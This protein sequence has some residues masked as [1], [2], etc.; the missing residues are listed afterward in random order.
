MAINPIGVTRLTGLS[1]G[2]DSDTII[3]NMMKIE[4]LKLDRELRAKT[5]IEWKQEAYNS[6]TKELTDFRQ[7]FLS[8]LSPDN[9][10]TG[11]AYNV[12]KIDTTDT[13]GNVKVTAGPEAAAGFVSVDYVTQ[14]AKGATAASAS[15]VSAG[16]T[17]LSVNNSTMLKDLTFAKDMGFVD[18]EISFAINGESFT[19]KET[20]S[21]SKMLSTVS[22]NEKAGVTLNYSRLTD[23][24]TL[25]TKQMGTEAK[26]EITNLKGNAF[27]ANG[28]LGIDTGTLSNGQNAKLSINGVEIERDSNRFSIDGVNY[29]LNKETA[30]ATNFTLTRDV[31]ASVNKIKTFVEGYNALVDKLGGMIT[32]KKE[33]NYRP[34][35]ELEKS[36]SGLSEKQID[37][38][39]TLAKQGILNNDPG[40]RNMLSSLRQALYTAVEGAG[41]SPA[42]I[43]LGT[44]YLARDGKISLDEDKLQ[45]ALESDPEMV[46]RIFTDNSE[47]AGSV[48]FNQKGM[49]YRMTDIFNQYN[50]DLKATTLDSMDRS[51][52]QLEKKISE[53]ETKMSK[54][55]E[56]YYLKFSAMEKAMQEL[57][58]QMSWATNMF[59][60]K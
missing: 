55:E 47:S 45:K 40:V 38:W 56:R 60:S 18:G 52:T 22:A 25:S 54:L 44:A 49:L 43:G 29:T 13:S 26:L 41:V 21:L 48:A 8:V 11:T 19:F 50:S 37:K 35:T 7:K 34:L 5:T 58:S 57:N 14:L 2:M 32:E 17:Q 36:E 4:Q 24:F 12:F 39:E 1:S 10:L 59:A 33:K 31:S 9:M 51:M 15:K 46:T 42:S 27:G 6:V 16:G 23:T 20:D 53:M 30:S 28:A 3:K